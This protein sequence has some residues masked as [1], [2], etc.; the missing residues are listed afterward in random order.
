MMR[1]PPLLSIAIGGLTLLTAG[2][3]DGLAGLPDRCT[4]PLVTLTPRDTTVHM[5]DTLTLHASFTPSAA[6]CL[7]GAT[8]ADLRWHAEGDHLAVDSLTGHV[9]AITVGADAVAVRAVTTTLGLGDVS[10]TVTQ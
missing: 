6:T 4:I 5:G 8:L 2:C 3:H 1:V 7:P 9:T 10:I